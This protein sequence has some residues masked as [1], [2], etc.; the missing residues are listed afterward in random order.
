MS[1][2]LSLKLRDDIYKEAEEVRQKNHIPRN[3]Y[4]NK[5][6]AFYTK[7][8]KREELRKQMAR[9]SYLVRDNS[10]EVLKE[11]EALEHEIP[12]LEW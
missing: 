8:L 4:I 10:M 9:S 6:V 12:G 7:W 1:K 2:A 11:F 5:A 3:A